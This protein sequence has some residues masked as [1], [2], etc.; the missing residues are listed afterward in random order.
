LDRREFIRRSIILGALGATGITGM[1]ALLEKSF[2]GQTTPPTILQAQTTNLDPPSSGLTSGSAASPSTATNSVVS[3]ST[4]SAPSASSSVPAGYVLLAALSAITGKT[5]AYFN[6]PTYGLSILI[7]Y[8]GAWKAFS[9]TCTH[10]GCT[11]NFTSS[12]LYCPCH[13][14][15]FSP[16]NGSVT[17]GPPPASLPEFDIKVINNYVYASNN[18]IN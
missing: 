13:A 15:Y 18:R 9:A 11:V 4:A 12:Q 3:S 8:N 10:A 6:H 17:S 2:G 1:I 7:N 5:Y 16:V 14:G